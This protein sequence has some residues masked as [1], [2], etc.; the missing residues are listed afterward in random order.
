MALSPGGIVG[1]RQ[2]G[3]PRVFVS[4][5][6]LDD[7]LPIAQAGDAV[8]RQLRDAGYPVEYRRF[9]GGHEVSTATS[10]AAVRWFLA[11]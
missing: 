6:T 9:V 4:H 3:V 5:G 8:V 2:V 7:V 10:A 1:D 11:G